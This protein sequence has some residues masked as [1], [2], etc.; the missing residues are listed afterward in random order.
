MIKQA[1]QVNKKPFPWLKA[2]SA[3][4]AAALPVMIGIAF[5]NLQYGLIA[6]LGGFTYYMCLISHMRSEQRKSFRSFSV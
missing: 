5:G 1:L 2:F 6:G 4:L 3:G